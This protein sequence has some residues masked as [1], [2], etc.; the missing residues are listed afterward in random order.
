MNKYCIFPFLSSTFGI[1]TKKSQHLALLDLLLIIIA[2]FLQI[3][4]MLTFEKNVRLEYTYFYKVCFFFS[5]I[6]FSEGQ[7]FTTE[8]LFSLNFFISLSTINY[9]WISHVCKREFDRLRNKAFSGITGIDLSSWGCLP[10]IFT[11]S[12]QSIFHHWLGEAQEF[13]PISKSLFTVYDC[14]KSTDSFIYACGP[15]YFHQILI[16]SSGWF[17]TQVC[18]YNTNLNLK[19]QKYDMKIMDEFGRAAS[20]Y[21]EILYTL[22]LS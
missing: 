18:I 1:I 4:S 22:L 14:E 13:L 17:H 10:K 12:S 11:R 2:L 15:W 20:E 9:S 16:R 5:S 21:D 7:A 3:T 8:F 6:I 19:L